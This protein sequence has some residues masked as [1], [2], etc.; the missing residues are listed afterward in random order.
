MEPGWAEIRV[1]E[2][3]DILISKIKATITGAGE[4][5]HSSRSSGP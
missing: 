5:V 4:I 1:I 3:E 2:I